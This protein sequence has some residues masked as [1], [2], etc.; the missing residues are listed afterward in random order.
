MP[1]SNAMLTRTATTARES[2]AAIAN[3]TTVIPA[4]LRRLR[5]QSSHIVALIDPIGSDVAYARSR[6]TRSVRASTV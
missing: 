2:N 3:V 5:Q 1:F 6:P 4:I